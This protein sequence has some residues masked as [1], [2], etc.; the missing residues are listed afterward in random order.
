MK[1]PNKLQRGDTIATI[2]PSWGCAGTPCVIWQYKLGCERLK[3][4]GLNVIAAPNSMKGTAYLD[5]NPQA[6]AEDINW[7]F[8]NKEV[9]AIISN[10]GGNDSA[11][12]FPYLSKNIIKNNPKIFCG[13]SDVMSLHLFCYRLGLMTFYGDNLLTTIA[14]N[15]KWHPYS[16]YWFKKTFFDAS[17]IGE[18]FPSDE[19]SYDPNK[20]TDKSYTKTFILNKGI[21]KIQGEGI[22]R[23]KL[24]GGHG[25][26]IHI[27]DSNGQFLVRDEDFMDSILFFEDIPEVSD[28][29]YIKC[30]FD[31]LGERGYLHLVNGIIIGKMRS[32]NSFK[33]YINAIKEIVAE[34]YGLPNLPILY[35]MNFGH[36]SPIFILPYGAMAELDVDNLKFTILENGVM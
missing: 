9:K 26:L 27:K 33:P 4:L 8:E 17:P 23:G 16:E 30:F 19:W 21:R 22:A 13:Y 31:C 7:A 34:K 3:E 15:P 14:E 20:H 6:R 24:F 35:D 12:L 36:S 25:D 11:R 5:Q 32:P 1:K 10:I 2:S 28:V 18:I 29:N